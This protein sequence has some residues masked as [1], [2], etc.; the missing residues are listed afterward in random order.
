MRC[1]GENGSCP[2][3]RANIHSAASPLDRDH[4]TESRPCSLVLARPALATVPD[5]YNPEVIGLVEPPYRL[6]EDLKFPDA[7]EPVHGHHRPQ[8]GPAPIG[9]RPPA[10]EPSLGVRHRRQ[11][12]YRPAHGHGMSPPSERSDEHAADGLGVALASARCR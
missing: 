1:R 10:P 9:P 8:T 6:D 3:R 2:E 5:P 4:L 12:E 11:E 7:L